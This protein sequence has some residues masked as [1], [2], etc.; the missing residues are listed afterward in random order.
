METNT[1]PIEPI[2]R[3]L[4]LSPSSERGQTLVP[5]QPYWN[6]PFLFFNEFSDIA[7]KIRAVYIALGIRGDAFR[8]A[9]TAGVRIRTRIGNEILDR[10]I[11]GAPNSNASLG[12]QVIGITGLWQCILSGV[13]PAIP[14]FRV[15]DIDYV[16]LVDVHAARPAKLEPL[17]D[18]LAV[19]VEDLDSVVLAVADEQPAAGIEGERVDHVE[20]TWAHAFCAPRLDEFSVLVQL[21]DSRV[22]DGRAATG[23][24]VANENVAVR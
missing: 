6:L 9:R 5:G 1:I 20:F 2:A 10:T 22:A 18:E 14:R 23:V 21:H 3:I 15:G 4:I 7:K 19:L 16:V 24:P 8:Q 12:A 13:G 17:G 11:A